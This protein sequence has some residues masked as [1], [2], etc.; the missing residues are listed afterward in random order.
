MDSP[1]P[2][3]S[4]VTPSYNQARFLEATIQSVLSQNYPRLEYIIMDGGSTDGSLEI[5]QRYATYLTY[6]VSE[7]DKGQVDAI[8]R[9]FAHSSGD[10]L[11]WINSDDTY[12]PG[13]LQKVAAIFNNN[14]EVNL[15]YGEGWYIDEYGK[16][17]KPCKFV[18]DSFPHVYITN[19]DPILQQAAFWRRSLWEK[20]G[21][22]ND[23]FNWV[24]DW[25]W[26][27][28]AHKQTK[29]YYIPEFL[30]D[31]RIQPQ[32]KTRS[33][34]IRRRVEQARITKQ[35]GNWWHPNYLV[36]QTRII[37]YYALKSF[38]PLPRSMTKYLGFL[39]SI[40]RRLAEALF[41]GRYVS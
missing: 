13:A 34:D 18:R 40:P 7:R 39:A 15:I 35:Y 9:G 20:I 17:I 33:T 14:P 36:Q 2:L 4:I 3:I 10:I 29:F 41:Y 27:I 19:K 26:F 38:R 8:N 28:R 21:P 25:E 37:E 11:G 22:L 16:R 23:T 1:K 24:F 5:I 31:Y 30:G 12:E 32:A 6:W